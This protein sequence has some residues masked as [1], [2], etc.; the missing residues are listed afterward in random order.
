MTIDQQVA[1]VRKVK[2]SES[3]MILDPVTLSKDSNVGRSFIYYERAQDWRY[4]CY[5]H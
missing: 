1:E 2:R 5:Q 3:G 4:S